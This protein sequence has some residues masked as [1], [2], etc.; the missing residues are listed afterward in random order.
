[1]RFA[2]V[3]MTLLVSASAPVFL[4]D[5]AE[6][7]ADA[8]SAFEQRVRL[9]LST[10]DMGPSAAEWQ[11]L[12]PNVISTFAEIYNDTSAP[13]F[14][15]A[16]TV[17]A[18]RFFATEASRTFLRAVATT[19]TQD[20]VISSAVNSLSHAFGAA[21][22][23]DIRPLIGHSAPTVR[24]AVV[25]A[26]SAMESPVAHELLMSRVNVEQNAV[27]QAALTNALR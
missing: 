27:V 16:R 4:A 22:L 17:Y 5:T 24:E 1:M 18:A 12:G 20:L 14:M 13:A 10:I 9:M 2:L 25:R 11:A 8:D 15:R 3:L 23:S 7:Q 6:A 26:L 21:A 19:S